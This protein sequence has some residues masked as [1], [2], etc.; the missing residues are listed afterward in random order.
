[1]SLLFVQW[2]QR[3]IDTLYVYVYVYESTLTH[4]TQTVMQKLEVFWKICIL[5]E[6]LGRWYTRRCD[7]EE[8]LNA[9]SNVIC[10]CKGKPSGEVTTCS[11][12]ECHYKQLHTTCLALD[13]VAIP[14]QWCG[15]HC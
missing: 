13:N 14:E 4:F 15:R 6:V 12:A 9:D 7:L 10:F 2:I 8:N 11:D 1:M 3:G 5:P